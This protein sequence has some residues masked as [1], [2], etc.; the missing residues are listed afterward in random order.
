MLG[1]CLERGTQR[2]DEFEG[3]M[4]AAGWSFS[5]TWSPPPE[6]ALT[7]EEQIES[8]SAEASPARLESYAESVSACLAESTEEGGA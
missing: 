4:E 7:Q 3:C 2:I 5:G 8:C 1:S 6:A